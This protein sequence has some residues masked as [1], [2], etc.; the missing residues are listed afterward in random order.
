M[1]DQQMIETDLAEL[2]DDNRRVGKILLAGGRS[3]EQAIEQRG[4]AGAEKAGH[5]RERKRRRHTR[6]MARGHCVSVLGVVCGGGFGEA[7]TAG[8]VFEPEAAGAALSLLDPGL[9][10]FAAL[11]GLAGAATAVDGG[12]AAGLTVCTGFAAGGF[13]AT[14]IAPDFFFAAGA[15]AVD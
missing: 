14:A 10:P 2:V 8:L 1:L 9:G 6:G 13:A 3:L 11:A 15:A 12:F 7:A 5:H 4:F